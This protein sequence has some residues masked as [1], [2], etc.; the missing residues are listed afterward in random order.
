MHPHNRGQR[1]TRR[2]IALA[3]AALF[4]LLAPTAMTAAAGAAVR[5]GA[6]AWLDP[7]ASW[8]GRAIRRINDRG[9]AARAAAAGRTVSI[10][11]AGTGIGT[12]GG[13]DSVRR[14]QRMLHDL[15]YGTGPV[16]GRFGP[17]TRSAVGWFQVKH[18]LDADGVVGPVTLTHL[19]RRSSGSGSTTAGRR[20]QRTQRAERPAKRRPARPQTEATPQ[21]R[22][23]SRPEPQPR[24][25]PAPV[26]ASPRPEPR[27]TPQPADAASP[28]DRWLVAGIA[29]LA[30]LAGLLLFALLR[31]RRRR[32][33]PEGTVVSLAQP[34]WVT[35][36]SSDPAIGPFAGT[37][38]AL[39]VSPPTH[40]PDDAPTIRY[41]V[42]DDARRAPLW[43]SSEDITETRTL[44]DQPQ[45]RFAD[46][47]AGHAAGG[48]RT[49]RFGRP[50][51]RTRRSG[52]GSRR[53]TDEREV[54][55]RIAW[56]RR[57]GMPP[58]AIADLLND[59]RVAPPRG[60]A[61]WSPESVTAVGDEV[62]RTHAGAAIGRPDGPEGRDDPGEPRS[63]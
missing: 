11:T 18:G 30:I 23:E 26:Q 33:P 13:S 48:V 59:E 7:A 17:R 50:G 37:A 4:L 63:G 6:P 62:T 38:A 58:E 15:G 42:I 1:R 39:H 57:H 35:G 9:D 45:R 54:A 53:L 20:P 24:P 32:R 52:A 25:A 12:P 3:T 21:R 51:A 29:V 41:C 27:E 14:V 34:L 43:V 47:L 44:S 19:Q 10:L 5:P 55:D 31:R 56:L 36:R 28:N 46:P 60:F 22:P 61:A 8:H 49:G 16:D 40:G 2:L